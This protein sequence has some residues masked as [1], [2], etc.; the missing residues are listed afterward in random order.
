MSGV[1][2]TLFVALLACT[3]FV[4]GCQSKPAEVAKPADAP[5]ASVAALREEAATLASRGDYLAAEKKYREALKLEPDSIEL[6]FGLG[7]VLSQLDRREAAAEE[8]RWVVANGRPGRPEV[9]AARRWLA[10]SGAAPSTAG[11]ASEPAA[12]AATLGSVSGK[13]TWPNIP[14]GM[15]FHIRVVVTRDSDSNVRKFARTTLNGT[16]SIADLPEGT[17]K[18]VGLAGPT[19]IWSDLNR[20]G[21][22]GELVTCEPPYRLERSDDHGR[23]ARTPPAAHSRAARA[24]GCRCTTRPTRA[25]RTRRPRVPS[26][27]R[28]DRS[29][30]P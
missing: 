6:H 16:F 1:R 9:D 5:T 15:S 12:E 10:E 19:R 17:Y 2:S 21:F 27:A 18:L 25:S 26:T 30:P 7:S 20:A 14:P 24:G 13:L 28:V 3:A 8:F 4:S 11:A 22:P 23:P 29:L